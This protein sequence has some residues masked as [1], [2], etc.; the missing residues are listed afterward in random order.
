MRILFLALTIIGLSCIWGSTI[1]NGTLSVAN[2]AI[3]HAVLPSGRNLIV[4]VTGI[5]LLDYWIVMLI[6]FFDGLTNGS[7]LTANLLIW[8]LL[9]VIQCMAIWMMT[10]GYNLREQNALLH[11]PLVWV[12]LGNGIGWA[13]ILPLYCLVRV[14]VPYPNRSGLSVGDSYGLLVASVIS[15]IPAPLTALPPFNLSQSRG[16]HQ[17]MIVVYLTTPLIFSGIQQLLGRLIDQFQYR[18]ESN[19]TS[20]RTAINA[21]IVAAVVAGLGHLY[22]LFRALGTDNPAATLAE[23]FIPIQLDKFPAD[24][25]TAG[26]HLFI[27][28]DYIIV[29][30]TCFC[31]IFGQLLPLLDIRAVGKPTLAV[32]LAVS[33]VLLGPGATLMLS[34]WARER[35]LQSDDSIVEKK[36]LHR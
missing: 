1:F 2:Y 26:S 5:P 20:R 22:V 27:Q 14:G 12:L 33:T 29:S 28:Y 32:G 36:A 23:V 6:A 8:D 24:L 9:C 3:A 15:F 19:G 13:F 18:K 4:S 11:M 21:Y 35:K 7:V 10:D 16:Q 34:L 25:L 30:L 17:A 31:Y